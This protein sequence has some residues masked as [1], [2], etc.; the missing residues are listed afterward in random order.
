MTR[1]VVL[2]N[3]RLLDPG[4]GLDVIGGLLVENGRIAALGAGLA[5]AAVA[6][7]ITAENSRA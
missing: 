1:P 2:V 3:A 6:D 4:S 5:D 7:A